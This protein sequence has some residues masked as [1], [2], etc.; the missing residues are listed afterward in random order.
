MATCEVLHHVKPQV[1]NA[2]HDPAIYSVPVM[3]TYPAL[4]DWSGYG[5]RVSYP[6]Q[7][8]TTG[9][10]S[11]NHSLLFAIPPVLSPLCFVDGYVCTNRTRCVTFITSSAIMC[12]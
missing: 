2:V 3:T 10:L 11:L 12:R 7:V 6:A 9:P 1:L 4:E 5:P 8:S